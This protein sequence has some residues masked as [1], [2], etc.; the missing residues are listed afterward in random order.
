MAK[1]T[2]QLVIEGKN[3]A[4]AAIKDAGND[5][6]TFSTAAKTAGAVLAGA[7]TGAALQDYVKTSIDAIDKTD[8]LAERVGMAAG[9]FAGLQ[10]AA[11]FASIEGEALAGTLTKFNQ[12]IVKAA[13]GSKVQAAA[14]DLIG[15]S[16]RDAEGNVK[17]AAQ[18]LGEVA[19]RFAEL[20][21]GPQKAALAIQLFGKQGAALLPLL[22]RGGAGIKELTDQARELGLVLDEETY[23]A[24]GQ[25]NDTL[26]VIASRSEGAGQQV[27]ANLLPAL[28]DLAGLYVELTTKTE[29]VNEVADVAGSILK[30]LATIVLVLGLAFKVTGGFLGG[31]TS[32]MLSLAEGNFK[33]ALDT[34]RDTTLD[35]V[36]TTEEGVARITKLWSGDYAQA[37]ADAAA[38]NK[39]LK[40]SFEATTSGMGDSVE[41][42]T[43][44]MEHLKAVQKQLV[45]DAKASLAEQVA[46]QKKANTE[47][48]AAKKAQVDT[49][50]RYKDA[51]AKLNAGG[52][53]DPS[54]SSAQALKVSAR[55]ALQQGNVEEAKQQA[56]AALDI[57]MELSAAGENTYG[58]GGF[59]KE[60]QGIEE[61]A[62][63]ISVSNAQASVDQATASVKKLGE[64]LEPVKDVKITVNLTPDEIAKITSQ[65]QGLAAQIGQFFTFQSVVIP[66]AG[67]GEA[68]SVPGYASGTNNA[69][70]GVRWVGE[71]GREL[72]GFGGGEKVLTH[73]ASEN[74]TRRLAGMDLPDALVG[75]LTDATSA[76]GGSS[77]GRDLGRVAL[78][79]GGE[80]YEFLAE[81]DPFDRLLR[82]TAMKVGRT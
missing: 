49:A 43:G 40:Q 10:Y 19:D 58:F 13:D 53:G 73:T 50:K 11:K 5:L 56:Q 71:R 24:A 65:M 25:F 42:A 62:D 74:L 9:E 6:A 45:A 55:N 37:G 21:D 1:V 34:L 75:G 64:A 54:Y 27:A 29:A 35:Y 72:V 3:N 2:T 52:D 7:I 76:V 47:L 20:P 82:R 17:G 30:G 63:G 22:N 41:E 46:A 33:G 15:V 31:L 77:P 61:A 78:D 39:L 38:T 26:D 8:E 12:N 44:H 69:S 14:F 57:L 28:N 32:A 59:I 23:A 48:E 68:A 16:V 4:K 70:A 18:L 67:G 79:L 66:P 36:T 81:Q 60:L 51:L 80:R